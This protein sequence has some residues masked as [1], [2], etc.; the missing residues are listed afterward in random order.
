MAKS[1]PNN[2]LTAGILVGVVVGMV[3]LSYASVP[4]YRLFC[5]I[6]GYGGTTA[7]ADQAPTAAEGRII[8]VR[9]DANVHSDLP[10][11][12]K[13]TQLEMKVRVGDTVEATYEARNVSDS[14]I[15]GT[16]T[17]NVTPYKAGPYFSKVDCFCFTEQQLAPGQVASL[18]VSFF[19]DPEIF[20]DPNTREIKT[21]TLSYTFFRARKSAKAEIPTLVNTGQDR[22]T[23]APTVE[24]N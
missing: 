5:Q 4:L 23:Q 2:H 15:T 3:G 21:I 11:V 14:D 8:T 10:W 16:S 17:Y 12:F 22:P 13:P 19:V 6:T 18:G 1:R 20:D 24:L 7:R 9:F